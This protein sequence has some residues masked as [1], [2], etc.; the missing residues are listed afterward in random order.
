[1]FLGDIGWFLAWYND[2]AIGGGNIGTPIIISWWVSAILEPWFWLSQWM[3][4][5]RYW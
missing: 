5:F 4:I 2:Y 1:M 3:L